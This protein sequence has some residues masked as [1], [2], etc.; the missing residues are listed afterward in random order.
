LDF[1]QVWKAFGLEVDKELFPSGK[2]ILI[3]ATKGSVGSDD[4]KFRMYLVQ[5]RKSRIIFTSEGTA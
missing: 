5:Y 1:A 2:L 4:D 3:S